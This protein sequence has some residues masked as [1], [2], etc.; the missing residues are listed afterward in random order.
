MKRSKLKEKGYKYIYVF[1]I[2]SDK[3]GKLPIEIYVKE[4]MSDEEIEQQKLEFLT[5]FL[6]SKIDG[7]SLIAL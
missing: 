7:P 6:D 2:C 5:N 3:L 1:D 4:K